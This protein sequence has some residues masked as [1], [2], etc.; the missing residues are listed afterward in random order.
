YIDNVPRFEPVGRPY[1]EYKKSTWRPFEVAGR[2][3]ETW[4]EALAKIINSP[5]MTPETWGKIFYAIYDQADFISIHHWK[6]GNHAT[7]EVADLGIIGVFYQEF[8]RA[9][10]WRNYSVKFLMGMWHELFHE[11]GYTKEMSG[12]YHWVAMRSYFSYYEVAQNNGFA[13]IF[14]AEFTERLI[15]N[16]LA[17]LYQDKP[18]YSIPITNDSNTKTNRKEQLERMAAAFEL[19]EIDYRL[20]DGAEGAPPEHTSF[21]FPVARVGFMRSDWTQDANYMFLDLGRW[22]DNHMNEDQL[23]IE[24]FAKGRPFLTNCGRWRYTTSDPT[25]PW[26]P[27]AR[28]FKTTASYNCVLVDDFLQI[29]GDADGYMKVYEKYDYAEGWFDEGFGIDV[30]DID[31]KEL[32]DKG[33]TQKKIKKLDAKHIRKVMFVKPDFWILRDE[34]FAGGEHRA[35]QVWH[36]YD[37]DLQQKGDAWVTQFDNANLVLQ[38]M[39]QNGIAPT[40]YK[41]S[42]DP[43]AGWHC[44]Y[45]DA[46]RPAPE[47]RLKQEGTDNIVFHTLLFPVK[48]SVNAL[49][50]FEV[51]DSGYN[52]TFAGNTWTIKAPSVGEWK[53][54]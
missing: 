17:E 38:T 18:D 45:Y 21:Y 19:P 22:G 5:A 33:V 1:L 52:V 12:G 41:G 7:L 4:P 35:E 32:K 2:I 13:G 43:I 24:V 50:I 15:C 47:L 9:E 29:N 46:K 53:L 34:V 30:A 8:K 26:M 11:D 42:D 27:W 37:G 6:T 44:T 49:P 14:P 54:V 10:E 40:Y 36:Y 39:G 16:S 51:A 28:Y 20:T 31:E 48:G 23:N 25:A 3:A